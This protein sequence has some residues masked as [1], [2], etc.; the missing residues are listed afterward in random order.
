VIVFGYN[1]LLDYMFVY[2]SW[3]VAVY[4]CGGWLCCV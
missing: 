4:S 1:V 2:V 3:W